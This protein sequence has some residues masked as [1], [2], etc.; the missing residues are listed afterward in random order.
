MTR[1]IF[2]GIASGMALCAFTLSALAYAPD[3]IP[4][5]KPRPIMDCWL[6]ENGKLDGCRVME[7]R[8]GGAA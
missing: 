6:D 7:A 8:K 4:R 1:F 2:I 5:H 3:D